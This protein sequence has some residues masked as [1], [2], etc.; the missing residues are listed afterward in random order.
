MPKTDDD[1]RRRKARVGPR[2]AGGKPLLFLDT[3]ILLDFYR[4]GR[5]ATK[6]LL[7]RVDGLHEHIITTYQ[8]EMEF[9]KNRQ[10]VI[11]DSLKQMKGPEQ[12]RQAPDFLATAKTVKSLKR[13]MR[14]ARER[15]DELRDR[16][17]KV[18]AD[19]THV[20]PVY[21]TFQRLFRNR[22]SPLHLSRDDNIRGEIRDLAL[23]RF[24]LGYPPRKPHDTSIGDAINWEWMVHVAKETA[25]DV[26]IVSRDS[27]YGVSNGSEAYVNDWLAQEFRARVSKKRKMSLAT[28]LTEALKLG[29]YDVT[30]EE[31]SSETAELKSL[32]ETTVMNWAERPGAGIDAQATG[33]FFTISNMHS[34][35]PDQRAA[36]EWIRSLPVELRRDVIGKLAEAGAEDIAIVKEFLDDPVDEVREMARQTAEALRKRGGWPG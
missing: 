25:N 36:V 30:D 5:G 11:L 33:S 34:L 8:V 20:D 32:W 27:D 3:N 6:D 13:I 31:I 21:R 14:T 22:A 12:F 26:I 9:K 24:Y 29:Q 10:N 23:K 19:P 7:H 4:F 28:R 2:E 17:T 1:G 16:V 18:M 35:S 15:M